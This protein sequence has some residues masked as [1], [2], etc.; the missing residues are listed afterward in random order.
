MIPNPLNSLIP[1]LKLAH[2]CI[3]WV[4][5]NCRFEMSGYKKEGNIALFNLLITRATDYR[6]TI[7]GYT[8]KF[9]SDHRGI[10]AEKSFQRL[11]LISEAV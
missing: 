10:L 9:R 1:I 2:Q 6:R 5:L 7:I 3:L 4:L 11:Y 8:G